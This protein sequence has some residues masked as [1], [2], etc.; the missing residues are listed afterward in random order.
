MFQPRPL[1]R[2]LQAAIRDLKD[3]KASVR[4]SALADLVRLAQGA[5]REP[6]IDALRDA[7]RADED[8][9]VRA[10]AALAL[11]DC[12][13]R[14]GLPELVDACQDVH[15]RV[16]Q[17]ALVALGE[18]S[19]HGHKDACAAVESALQAESPAL[20]FQ[21]LIAARRVKLPEFEPHLLRALTDQDAKVRYLALRL[22]EEHWAGDTPDHVCGAVRP[23][24]DDEDACVRVAAAFL[25]A[26]S[27]EQ[28]LARAAKSILADALNA[29]VQLPALED[30]Q[31]L[32]ELAGELGVTAAL[33][34]LKRHAWGLF[35]LVPGRFAWQAKVALARLGEERARRELLKGLGAWNRDAR[36]LAVAAV[37]RARL[38]EAKDRLQEMSRTDAAEPDA[39]AEAL[40]QL[41]SAG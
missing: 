28:Q 17:M 1:P 10:A 35:G 7:L 40:R 18:L 20:R 19:P 26:P 3:R 16:R 33:P 38:L 25:L 23:A 14:A 13:A 12:E 30:E 9:E 8:A 2:T 5:D 27:S 34:G 37:G 4:R 29:R 6:T 31:E 22:I 36:T 39:I 11:A 15:A 21:A 32:I 24:L 41:R